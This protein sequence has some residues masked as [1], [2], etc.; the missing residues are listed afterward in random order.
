M[1]RETLGIHSTFVTSVTSDP[2]GFG[3]HDKKISNT[4]RPGEDITLYIEPSGLEY[5]AVPDGN[6]SPLYTISYSA[7]FAI[8][9][10]EGYLLTEQQDISI[11]E[12][13]SKL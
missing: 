8:S 1:K 9:N 10:T 12:I 4:F 2:Q 7:G 6:N 3:F 11:S 13:K 5:G